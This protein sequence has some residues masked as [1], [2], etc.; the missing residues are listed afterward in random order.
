M[1]ES[2]EN[3]SISH[4]KVGPASITEGY[5]QWSFCGN[6]FRK[7]GSSYIVINEGNQKGYYYNINYTDSCTEE[8]YWNH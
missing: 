2:I 4:R 6:E 8:K 5:L 3:T 1:I 7:D